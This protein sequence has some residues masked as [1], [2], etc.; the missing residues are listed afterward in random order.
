MPMQRAADDLLSQGD[1]EHVDTCSA[2]LSW[3][4]GIAV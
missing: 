3:R 4:P 2:W 1:V